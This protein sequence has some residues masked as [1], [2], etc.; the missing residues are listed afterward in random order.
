[1]KRVLMFGFLLGC[2]MPLAQAGV[3]RDQVPLSDT[4]LGNYLR[5]LS[6]HLNTLE[7]ITSDPDGS[8]LGS[9][10][11]LLCA[12]YDSDH[13]ICMNTASGPNRGTTW[14][15]AN[16]DSIGEGV[17]GA[18]GLIQF[19]DD[20]TFDCDPAFIWDDVTHHG[21]FGPR[22]NGTAI[23][24]QPLHQPGSLDYNDI[25][26]KDISST[27]TM[28]ETKTLDFNF[29]ASTEAAIL[30]SEITINSQ[31]ASDPLLAPP[32]SATALVG[33]LYAPNSLNV[34]GATVGSAG[35]Y[36][37]RG[38]VNVWGVPATSDETVDPVAIWGRATQLCGLASDASSGELDSLIAGQFT[39]FGNNQS[40]SDTCPSGGGFTSAVTGVSIN[41]SDGLVSTSGLDVT[42]SSTSTTAENF[43]INA[44]LNGAGFQKFSTAMSQFDHSVG[45]GWG[46]W[47]G[48]FDLANDLLAVNTTT[49]SDLVIYGDGAVLGA[50]AN[51]HEGRIAITTADGTS[52]YPSTTMPVGT[53][54]F[55]VNDNALAG[56]KQLA[57]LAVE[58]DSSTPS[59]AS[60]PGRLL[61]STRP[62]GSGSS[63]TERMR[64]D[65][66]GNVGIGD[67]SPGSKLEVGGDVTAR[68]VLGNGSAPSVSTCGTTPSIVGTD[69]A[70]KVT[71]GTG[72]VTSCTLTFATAWGNAPSCFAN[73]E[74]TSLLV[75]TATTTTV[76]TI[77]SATTMATNVIAYGCLG[78]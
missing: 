19:S 48:R 6:D 66:T 2:W 8:V 25:S 53:I 7:C 59:T 32:P 42:V 75:S 30:S 1:M 68:H 4:A 3:P 64:I 78:F 27:V 71:I 60:S 37:I 46:Q 21:A 26:T 14:T 34:A 72:V 70:G 38:E 28:E 23:V 33:K 10:G 47:W 55:W 54:G 44:K 39:V 61:F 43:P 63:I 35:L 45:I 5:S 24:D 17:C 62:A 41:A 56:I 65:S 74:S 50:S 51:S 40:I 15:C 9:H 67:T 58:V 52:S 76:L 11:Q 13:H 20:S 31:T 22:A 29:S 12:V 73:D 69:M 36:G 57:N 77:T 18:D 49:Q 16:I